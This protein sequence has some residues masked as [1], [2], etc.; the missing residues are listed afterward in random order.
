MVQFSFTYDPS[1][2]LEQRV[3]FELAAAIWGTYLTDDITVSL[4]I[5]SSDNLGAD[6]SAVGGAVPMFY[7]QNYGVYQEYRSLMT[8]G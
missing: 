1:I 4:H 2:S 8:L 6:G 7:E 5:G 3:G